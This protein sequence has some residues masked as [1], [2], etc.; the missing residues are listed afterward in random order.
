MRITKQVIAAVVASTLTFGLASCSTTGDTADVNYV[1]VNGT[2][3][4]RGLIPGD[5]NEN[6]GGRVVD[7]LYSG[8]VYF[9]EAGVAQNDLA[10]SIDQESDTTY[11]VTLREGIKFS[12]GSAITANDFVASWNFVVANG[13]LNTSFFSPI[14][15]YADGVESLDGLEVLDDRTFTI[16]LE[17][18]DSEFTQRIGY[19]GFAPMPASARD[20]IDAFGENPVSSGPY[21]LE[22]WDH[23]A[24]LKVV[25]NEHYDGPRMAQNDGLKYVFYAQN[26]AAYSDLLAGNLD[27]LDLIPPSAYTTYEDELSGRSINQPAASYLEL[28]IRMESPNFEGEQGGLRRQAISMAINREEIAQEIFN[29][30]YTPALD[31]TVPV[32][33]GWRDD[34]EGNDVLLFQPDKARELWEEAEK[35][36]PFEGELQISYNADVPNREWVDAVANSISNELGISAIGNPFPDFKS[37][38][39][40]YRT[41]GLDGAYRTAWFAD[42]PSIGNFLGP[43]YT[44]GVASNDSKYENPEFDQ[45]IKDAAAAPTKEDT[46]KAY[47]QAQEMLLRDLPAIPLWYP[48]VVGG[49]SEAVDN[50][51]VNW[52]AIPVYWAI[53]KQ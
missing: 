21:K 40:T 33:E 3:P 4:Q 35:I 8:L 22:Q 37:F 38:R 10:E 50:V 2:E 11:K 44:T 28:S 39:D 47:E 6:G 43:N 36:E 13:L 34:L 27:V 31:F 18:P 45:L 48:N 5:T 20:D 7:M 26:D 46:F 51:S 52:K 29:G 15:G 53:T 49:Y 12:D 14:K 24:E 16:E 42:Y 25:V 32:L 30:T 19:Y 1:S 9:D 23:N 17:Q 41:T